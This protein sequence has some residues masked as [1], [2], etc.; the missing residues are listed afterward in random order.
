VSASEPQQKRFI[1]CRIRASPGLARLHPH[2]GASSRTERYSDLE[3]FKAVI[4]RRI[5]F[6]LYDHPDEL[7]VLADVKLSVIQEV[8]IVTV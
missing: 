7:R 5:I 1:P 4:E 8:Q 3:K 6:A 2:S